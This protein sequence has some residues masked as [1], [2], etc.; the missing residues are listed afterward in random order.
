[1]LEPAPNANPSLRVCIREGGWVN[2]GTTFGRG[3]RTDDGA[4][5]LVGEVERGIL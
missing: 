2:G 3:A 1:M 4:L 5:L